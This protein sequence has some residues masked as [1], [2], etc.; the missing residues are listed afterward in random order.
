MGIVLDVLSFVLMTAGGLFVL[1]GGIGVVRLPNFY[2]RLHAAGIG[3]SAGTVLILVGVMLQMDTLLAALKAASIL[4]FLILAGPT[5]TYAVANAA[6][7]AG[8]PTGARNYRDDT[9]R[10]AEGSRPSPTEEGA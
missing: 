7:R 4:L 3:D 5:A 1:I 10:P 6:V 9:D 8:V 2:T